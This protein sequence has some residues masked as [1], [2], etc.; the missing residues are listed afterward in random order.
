MRKLA[1]W[2]LAAAIVVSL[3]VTPSAAFSDVGAGL[4]GKIE[5]L[6]M[7]GIVNGFSDGTFRPNGTL[8]RAQFCK[9][10]VVALGKESEI[11]LFS[12]YTYYP[13]VRS[14]HWAA[15]YVN[16]AVKSLGIISGFP[17][18]TF[19]PDS[20][21]NYAQAITIIVRALGYADGVDYALK[22]PQSNLAYAAQ[23][24]LLDGISYSDS[25]KSMPRSD[26]VTL[27]F[28]MLFAATKAGGDFIDSLGE[29]RDDAVIISVTETAADGTKNA[30]LLAG[31]TGA[32]KSKNPMPQDY[33]GMK[34]KLLLDKKRVI[35][36]FIPEETTMKDI[37]LKSSVYP[38]IEGIGGEKYTLA[39]DTRIYIN[40]VEKKFIDVW[41]D[42]AVGT[43]LRLVFNSAGGV[44]YIIAGNT[45]GSADGS[46]TLVLPGEVT[47]ETLCAMLGANTGAK[48]Y[49]YNTEIKASDLK[50]YDVVTYNKASNIIL[51]SDFKLSG[52]LE[53]A[54][55]NVTAP[56]KINTFGNEF[57]V[58]ES[59]ISTLS[60]FKVGSSLT[61]LFTADG[62]VAAAYDRSVLSVRP[63]GFYTG[64]TVTFFNGIM[65][66]VSPGENSL[67]KDN[68]FCTV[69]SNKI[70]DVSLNNYSVAAGGGKLDLNAGT[71]GQRKLSPFAAFFDTVGE[72]GEYRMVGGSDLYLNE[73]PAGGIRGVVLDD[74]NRVIAVA[75]NDLTGDCY[76]YGVSS[77]TSRDVEVSQGWDAGG[78][79]IYTTMQ[80]YYLTITNQSGSTEYKANTITGAAAHGSYI[81][82]A[83]NKAGDP[84]GYVK[85]TRAG[86]LTR[87]S[88][89]GNESMLIN[90]GLM[91]ISQE[92][93]VYVEATGS[94]YKLSDY[95]SLATM[96]SSARAFGSS[97]DAYYDRTADKG[98]K[99]RIIVIK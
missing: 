74:L 6:Q 31:E 48:L 54:Y 49:M 58:L 46:N 12:G 39:S 70:G 7:L 72:D 82:I 27:F 86:E 69:V 35:L 38:T 47:H 68:S 30:V 77:L 80:E 34:G 83:K 9:M 90:G 10:A 99:V 92:V 56:T 79:P 25:M 96:I 23:L 44:S 3:F 51:V 87:D 85:L 50:R 78:K 98:G 33:V 88:F 45:S 17:D 67:V 91:K 18:G 26:G 53:N 89:S 13:D 64:N 2:V 66:V 20:E 40:G 71:L 43:P 24:G 8:T 1:T 84:V 60:K 15:G 42:M 61:F 41:L 22:W 76:N 5:V 55:P 14:S 28:N 97:F 32:I 19:R 4:S 52:V 93:G 81:G 21:I 65:L 63:V 36:A 95:A 11:G 62:K 29:T 94:Y 59:A 37:T 75:F 57:A 73:I 16:L